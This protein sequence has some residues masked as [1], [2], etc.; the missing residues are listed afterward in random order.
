MS[1]AC[2]TSPPLQELRCALQKVRSILQVKESALKESEAE[3]LSLLKD[4]DRSVTQLRISLQDKE[5][6]LQVKVTSGGRVALH[7]D[8]HAHAAHVCQPVAMSRPLQEYSEMVESSGSSKPRDALLEKLRE[9]IKD[10]DRALEVTHRIPDVN[11]GVVRRLS[12]LRGSARF[13]CP[14]LR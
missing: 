9:R 14:S 6:Q 3:R 4:R 10:R 11:V 13:L 1:D 2:V 12:E 8:A 5:Q 7:V